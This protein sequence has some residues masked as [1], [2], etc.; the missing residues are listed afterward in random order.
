MRIVVISDTHIPVVA[1]ELPVQ[2]IEELK[3]SDLC[4]HAGDIVDIKTAEEIEKYTP[5]KAVYGNMDYPQVQKK[6]PSQ[7]IFSVEKFKIGVIH[8]GGAPFNITERIKKSFS[9][10]LDLYIFGHTHKPYDKIHEDKIFFNPGSPTDKFFTSSNYYGIIE[11]EKDK[12]ERRII[13]IG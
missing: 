2:I 9:Q 10:D 13:K 3:K 5:L 12:I 4:I 11:I 1:R 6:F 8:G 7:Q